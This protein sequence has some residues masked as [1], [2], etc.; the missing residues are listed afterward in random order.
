MRHLIAA[1]DFAKDKPTALNLARNVFSIAY[2]LKDWKTAVQFVNVSLNLEP[3]L[4]NDQNFMAAARY[5]YGQANPQP[6]A[7]PKRK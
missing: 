1:I 5:A 2:E 6:A 3:N 4:K 7:A